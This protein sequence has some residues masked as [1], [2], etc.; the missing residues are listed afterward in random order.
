MVVLFKQIL[1]DTTTNDTKVTL[2]EDKVKSQKAY[3]LVYVNNNYNSSCYD[4]YKV[5]DNMS[6]N[7]NTKKRKKCRNKSTRNKII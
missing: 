6:K 3:V 1:S 7:Q 4:Y 2:T 5:L